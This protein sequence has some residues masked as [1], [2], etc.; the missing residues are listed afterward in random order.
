MMDR[1]LRIVAGEAQRASEIVTR[2]VSFGR[3]ENVVPRL[4]ELNHLISSLKRFRER[5]WKTQSIRVQ[6]KLWSESLPVMAAQGLLE[7]V[8]LSILVHAEQ[9]VLECPDKLITIGTVSMAKRSVVEV[10][11]GCPEGAR[12]PFVPQAA[13]EP[14]DLGLAVVRGILRSHGGDARFSRAGRSCCIEVDLPS[15]EP[16]TVAP[17]HVGSSRRS[18]RTLTTLVMDPEPLRQRQLVQELARRDHRVVPVA[19]TEEALDLVGRV[20]FDLVVCSAR[21]PGL[22]WVEFLERT[23]EQV[24]AYVLIG[25]V[26][27]SAGFDPHTSR[28]LVLEDATDD[29]EFQRVVEQAE[30]VADAP[31]ALRANV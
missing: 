17:R 22:N 20:R 19:R 9:S 8:F 28:S 31:V 3:A 16:P 25:G 5:E 13:T 27:D 26:V 6:E 30:S 12:D 11:F 24:G 14:G 7:Q 2:L 1:E 29:A 15:A 23:R 10:T 18:G 4:V 21:V